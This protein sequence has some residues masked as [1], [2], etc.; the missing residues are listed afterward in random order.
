M[1]RIRGVKRAAVAPSLPTGRGRAV[2]IDAGANSECTVEQLVQFAVMGAH[3]AELVLGIKNPRVGLLNI[4]AEPSKGTELYQ[5]TWK[6]LEQLKA[7]RSSTSSAT[8]RAATRWRGMPTSLWQ[9][10]SP[11]ISF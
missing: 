5:E 4:G 2:L 8:W 6:Q 7:G 11:A 1:R 9:M 3:Y 10:G